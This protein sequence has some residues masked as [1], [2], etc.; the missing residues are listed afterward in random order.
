M[1]LISYT[2]ISPSFILILNSIQ[3]NKKRY[4]LIYSNVYDET[5]IFEV[6]IHEKCKN[7]NI[8]RKNAIFSLKKKFYPL[9]IK[10]YITS[11]NNVLVEVT[12]NIKT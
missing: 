8:L 12:F 3:E 7:L 6:W 5:T 4:F 9:D 2:N 11:K 10:D 1:L